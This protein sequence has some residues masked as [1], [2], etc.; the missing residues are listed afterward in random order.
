MSTNDQ[1]TAKIRDALKALDVKDDSQWTDDGLPR[2]G[3]VKKLA[4]DQTITRKEIQDALPGFQRVPVEA[5]KTVVA[6]ANKETGATHDA[7]TGDPIVPGES[8]DVGADPTK[9]TGDFM[10]DTE[11]RALLESRLSA[12]QQE[13]VDAQAAVR[14]AQRR[15]LAANAAVQDRRTDLSREFPPMTAAENVK[16]YIAS[17]MAQRELAARGQRY[18]AVA[19]GS[20]IDAAMQRGNSRGWRRP[21]RI[22]QTQTGAARVA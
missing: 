20:Q 1:K 17:E 21:T 6:P 9:N 7:I 19:P 11:V 5:K 16:A 15:V 13:V 22:G 12:A 14:D 4:N 18:S 10:S 3:A 2:E 8:L